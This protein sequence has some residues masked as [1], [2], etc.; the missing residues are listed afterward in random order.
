MNDISMAQSLTITELLLDLV[1]TDM[2]FSDIH[3][4][5]DHPVML[6]MP[7]GWVPAE[8]IPPVTR[9]DIAVFLSAIDPKWEDT[10]ATRA[11][12]RAIDLFSCRLRINAFPI[13]GGKSYSINVRRQ[14]LRPL[15]LEETGLPRFM[16]VQAANQNGLIL[17]TG[18][19]GSGKTTTLAS[20]VDSINKNRAA[21]IITIEDPIEFVHERNRSIISSKE[22]GLDTPSFAQGLHDALRQKPDVIVVGEIRD[23]QTADTVFAA[24]ESGH[25]VLATLHTNSALG[26]LSKLL[27]WFPDELHHRSRMLAASLQCVIAQTLIPSK[28]GSERVLATEVLLNMDRQVAEMLSDPTR[29]SALADYM[30]MNKD[31]MSHNLN[32]S[33]TRLLREEKITSREAMNYTNDRLE[34]MELIKPKSGA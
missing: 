30:R 21:H 13:S 20:M 32:F 18:Q 8:N 23:R 29:H 33:I 31:K 26:A 12:S 16:R 34:L 7:S 9:E 3:F 6:Q 15:P 11:V 14:P 27:S 22:V 1:S 5:Q 17:V 24:A 28:D 4:E 10:I 25:L 19:T 2:N